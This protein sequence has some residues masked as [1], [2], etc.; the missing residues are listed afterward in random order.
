[1]TTQQAAGA[2]DQRRWTRPS[3]SG[4]AQYGAHRQQRV[5][6]RGPGRRRQEDAGVPP[7]YAQVVRADADVDRKF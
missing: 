7:G 5:H 2:A 3:Q 1:R 6:D 4:Q